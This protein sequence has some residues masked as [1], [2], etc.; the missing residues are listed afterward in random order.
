MPVDAIFVVHKTQHHYTCQF[1]KQDDLDHELKT[2]VLPSNSTVIVDLVFKPR[3]FF[4]AT[5]YYLGCDGDGANTK[6]VITRYLNRFI[7]KGDGKEII[8]GP[9]NKHMIDV[10]GYYHKRDDQI[11]SVSTPIATAFVLET[12]SSGSYQ[13]NIN[14]TGDEFRGQIRDL[15]IVVEDTPKTVMRCAIRKHRRLTCRKEGIHPLPRD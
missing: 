4:R 14:F 5:E 10:Y 12:K 8:P 13:F 15:M 9:G 6:P 3:T 2:I 1:A 11:F 7:E